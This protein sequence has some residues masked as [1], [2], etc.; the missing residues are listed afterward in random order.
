MTNRGCL[1]KLGSHSHFSPHP[2]EGRL[3]PECP[4][5]PVW[6]LW[7]YEMI[8]LHFLNDNDEYFDIRMSPHGQYMGFIYKGQRNQI[9]THV[10]EH[11]L[12][13]EVHNP[14]LKPDGMSVVPDCHEPWSATTIL[15][16]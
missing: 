5:M 4:N 11:H 8:E 16:R 3:H 14:C 2:K 6:G 13:V 10:P 7:D 15:S 12:T 9:M 1:C